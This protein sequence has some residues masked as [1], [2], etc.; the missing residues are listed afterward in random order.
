[1]LAKI[2]K[3]FDQRIIE[4]DT[5]STSPRAKSGVAALAYRSDAHRW[6]TG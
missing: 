5:P 3:F 6:R 4:S 1:M 2:A